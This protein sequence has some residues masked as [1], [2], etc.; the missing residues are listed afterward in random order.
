LQRL[1]VRVGDTVTV[2]VEGQRI[3]VTIVGRY[4]ETE[5]SG[6]VLQV[7]WESIATAFPDLRPDEYFVV[8]ASGT[9]RD[10]LAARLG[11]AFG[12]TATVQA[13]V[14]DTEDLDAF[15]VAFWLVAGLVLTVALANLA[16][17][18]LLGVRERFRDL[19]VL[20]AV[21]FTPWQLVGSTAAGTAA[22]VLVAVAAGIPTGMFA[23]HALTSTVGKA[24]GYGPEFGSAPAF[25]SVAATIAAVAIGAVI[26]GTAA[27]A[28]STR[29]SASELIRY[30]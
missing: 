1:G 11:S 12:P 6:E 18:I 24:T 2:E 21:G 19:G 10:E 3:P 14:V 9:S 8:A 7:R 23:N 15:F 20:R 16:S 27:S 4:A 5:D 29:R 25:S 17:T 30:E 28:G 13:L 26:V 22:L